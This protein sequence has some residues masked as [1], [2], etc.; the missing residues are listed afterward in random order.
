MSNKSNVG[1]WDEWYKDFKNNETPSSYKY[2]ETLTYKVGAE[3]LSDCETIED[4]GVG[5]GGFLRHCPK[6]IGVD[7]SDTPFAQKKHVDL[8]TYV[9]SVEGVHMRHVL[10][11]NY[12]WAKVLENALKSATKKLCITL[13]IPLKEGDTEELAHNLPHGVDVPDLAISMDEFVKIIG[14]HKPKNIETQSFTTDTGYKT[15]VVYKISF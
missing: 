2:G 14:K 6:A 11:H 5:G 12:E 15:E 7:G 13:F 8:C 4:W 9:S 10:E 3:F 1:K